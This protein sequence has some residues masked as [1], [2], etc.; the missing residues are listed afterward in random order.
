[1]KIE[2]PQQLSTFKGDDEIWI[3]GLWIYDVMGNSMEKLM[4]RVV[5]ALEIVSFC[6][7][8]VFWSDYGNT[9]QNYA[10]A[11]DERTC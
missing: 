9:N 4:T 6:N 8:M 2:G 3:R 7:S 1:M 11:A 10:F 5:N